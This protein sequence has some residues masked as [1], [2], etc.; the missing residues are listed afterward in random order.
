MDNIS[1][2]SIFLAVAKHHNFSKA[3]KELGMT[4]SAISKQ[5]QKLENRLDVTL[6]QRTTRN[7]TLTEEGAIY[8]ERAHRAI[9]DLQEAENFIQEMKTCPTGIL[10]VSIPMSFGL[11]YMTKPIA[12]FANKYPDVKLEVDF[13][14]RKV[15]ILAESYDLAVRIGSLEDSSFIS[16]KI[17]DCP[18]LICATPKYLT[19]Y[20][21]PKNIE[22]LKDHKTLIFTKHS[23]NTAWAYKYE[24]KN[25]SIVLNPCLKAN[26]GEMLLASCLQ[27]VGI[28]ALPI[29]M[30]SKYIKSGEL[31]HILPEYEILSGGGI[32]AIFPQ[33]R[34]LSTRVRLFLE[35]LTET[36]KDLPW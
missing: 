30:V 1:R 24:N 23:Q 34:H 7:V 33:N 2:I 18:V 19:K 22:Q 8:Q 16:R 15:D 32:Y 13:D 10:K 26:N 14:D 28:C 17:A 35:M 36:G 11:Q 31:I 3:G 9:S 20:G 5:I 29:F 27:N 6:F 4:G 12:D 25:G 21:K